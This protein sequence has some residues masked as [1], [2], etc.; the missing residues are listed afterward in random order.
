MTDEQIAELKRL[1]EEATPGP[2]HCDEGRRSILPADE[3]VA[4]FP[5]GT[6]A[7]VARCLG[8]FWRGA[9]NAPEDAGFIR[10]GS[11]IA[12]ARFI[13][14]ANPAAV[15][16]LLAHV[17]M[18]E[19]RIAEA[20]Q[21]GTEAVNGAGGW[22]DVLTV[23]THLRKHAE[24]E[25]DAL[26]V[27]LAAQDERIRELEA[28]VAQAHAEWDAAIDRATE[29]DARWEKAATE[30]QEARA[31]ETAAVTRAAQAERDRDEARLYDFQDAV[32]RFQQACSGVL[33]SVPTMPDEATRLLRCRLLLEETLEYIH[34][35]GYRVCLDPAGNVDLVIVRDYNATPNPTAMAHENADVLVI[36]FGNA[37]AMG[38][39]MAPVFAEVMAAN[40]RKAQGGKVTRRADGKV[41]KPEGWTPADVGAVLAKQGGTS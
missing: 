4:P 39:D 41:L 1:A 14:A 36:A 7:G 28:V 24:S 25:R 8:S 37:L 29:A 21:D 27:R 38:V 35:S 3:M 32:R 18:L 10:A 17:A 9:G 5:D 20:Q 22:R 30:V 33:P 40:M 16:G 2:W 19:A 6:R 34:A 12:N 23:E 26:R 31:A 13:A 15:L 11:N